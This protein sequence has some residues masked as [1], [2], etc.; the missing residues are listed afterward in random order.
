MPAMR[1]NRLPKW[2]MIL[3]SLF[4]FTVMSGLFGSSCLAQ[5]ATSS[6]CSNSTVA[7]AW[8]PEFALQAKEFFIELQSVVRAGNKKQF[9]SLVR[10]P[11][12][13]N[14]MN[15][16]AK[17]TSS[18]ELLSRYSL[19]ITPDAREAIL[20]QSPDCLF[21]NGQGVMAASGR[22]WF[23]KQEDG[24]FKIVTLNVIRPK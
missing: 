13:V 21:G 4:V 15:E 20:V 1:I 10:F 23:Q 6:G 18:S 17:I 12:N 5:L 7:D 14:G 9:A 2:E 19:I 24:K 22:L 11:L 8:G 16:V 3:R